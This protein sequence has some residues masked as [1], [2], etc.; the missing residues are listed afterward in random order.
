MELYILDP[1]LRRIELIDAFES[2]IWTERWSSWG[3]FEL[4]IISNLESRS[5]LRIGTM[6]SM[7]LS[8]RV[9]TVETVEDVVEESGKR[10]LKVK[11]RSIESIFEDR[12]VRAAMTG[13]NTAPTWNITGLPATVL[14]RVVGDICVDGI[15]SPY[16][17]IPYIIMGRHPLLPAD[18]IA[19]PG[20]PI[21]VNLEPQTV[22]DVLTNI[23]NTWTM[24]FRLLLETDASK[25]YFDVYTGTDRTSANAAKTV[26]FAPELDNLQNTS[27]LSSMEDSKNV[28]YVFAMNGF[29]VVKPPNVD[30]EVEGFERRVLMV[31]ADDITLPPGA[32]LTAAMLQRGKE[33]LAEHRAF[34]AFDGEINQNSSYLINRDYYLGD[35]VEQRNID[36]VSNQMRVTE[37]IYVSDTEGERSYPTLALNTFIQLGS[38]LSF[39]PGRKWIDYD[40]DTDTVW[41]V[42]P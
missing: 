13:M 10:V 4:T 31:K 19:T 41:S 23:S 37:Q 14:R 8:L 25:L 27:E 24:G 36:G 26:I 11:G 34:Q 7:N 17:K 39:D 20:D 21:T 30:N 5:F 40:A 18:S 6:V 35:L 32:E 16:D 33:A 2:L 3:D 28:A 9:M 38:W 42:L 12:A 29:L 15:L 1:L 22:Y